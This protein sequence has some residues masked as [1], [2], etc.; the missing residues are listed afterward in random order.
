[1]SLGYSEG[2]GMPTGT[3]KWKRSEKIN[4]DWAKKMEFQE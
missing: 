1:M 3:T 2:A 4:T